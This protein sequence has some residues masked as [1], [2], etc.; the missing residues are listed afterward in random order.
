MFEPGTPLE[1]T[2]HAGDADATLAL[3][4][5]LSA[6]QRAAHRAGLMRMLKLMQAARWGSQP[7]AWGAAPTPP[8]ERSLGIAV[9]LCGTANDVVEAMVDDDLI[10]SLGQEFKPRSLDGLADAM[11]KHSPLWIGAAQRLIAAALAPRPSADHYTL[12]LIAL[13]R[14]SRDKARLSN[15]FEADSGLRPALLRVFDIEGTADVSLASVDKYNHDPALG[16]SVILLSLVDDGLATHAQLLDRTLGALEKDWPQYRAGWFSRFHAVL[17][18]EP[19]AMQPHLARYLALCA[20]RIAPTVTLALDALHRL[21]AARPI[22]GTALLEALRPVMS[23]SVKAQLEAAMKLLDDVVAREPSLAARASATAALALQHEAGAVQAS[24]LKRL[25]SWGVDGALRTQLA[26]CASTMAAI[27]RPRLLRL[28]G[29]G[30]APAPAEAPP[31]P[32]APPHDACPLDDDRRLAAF[33]DVHDLVECIAHVFEHGNDVDAFER[34]A[35]RLVEMAPIADADVPLFA[36]VRKR[37]AKVRQ[38]L[39]RELARLLLFVLDGTRATGHAGSDHGGNASRVEGLHNGRIDDLMDLAAQRK[40]LAPLSAPTHRGG[41]IAADAFVDRVAAHRAAGLRSS[42]A[43]QVRGLLRLAMGVVPGVVSRAR[44]LPDDA[45]T[46]A[47]RYALGDDVA[48]GSERELFAAAARIRHPRSDDVALDAR[49]PGLGP[50][51]AL[52]ARYQWRVQS[53]SHTYDGKTYMHHDLFV[54]TQAAPADAPS[55]RIAVLRHASSGQSRRYYR[56]WSFAGID[57]GAIRLSA[58]LLPSDPEAF[59]AEGAR[60]I[61]NN[62]DWSEAQWQNRA[63]L[64]LLL[65]PVTRMTPMACLLLALGLA[66][67]EPGQTA[68]AVD[69][70]VLA[71]ADGRLDAHARLAHALRALLA[72]PLV[73]PARLHKSFLAAMRASPRIHSLVFDLLCAALQARPQDPPKDMAL[74]LDL[75]LE[76]KISGS[77]AVPPDVSQALAGMKLTGK[78][79]ALQRKLLA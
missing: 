53:S 8:Q 7:G 45:F 26:N 75:S 59:L 25:E 41:F 29:A 2:I 11:L 60:A 72:T 58:T 54:E 38:L 63:Y 16:W 70:L 44:G 14:V 65:D 47:L 28:A 13:P 69:A 62:L 48:P 79:R 52:V 55:E 19:T 37:A 66:G 10:V 5:G 27:N 6:E 57:E 40:H 21:N 9:I 33:A 78:A 39:P 36:P 56:W 23:A 4:R 61:G 74:L 20:S 68:I 17:A 73:K 49:H 22:D 51:A 24:V 31:Q 71:H 76:L 12:G 34:A 50:D 46:R 3:L 43:E 67:K 35:A 30:E 42:E 18:P 1:T 77:R 15:L 64:E 32:S